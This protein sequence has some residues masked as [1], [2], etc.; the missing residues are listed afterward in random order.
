MRLKATGK[1]QAEP[2]YMVGLTSLGVLI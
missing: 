1:R 2:V